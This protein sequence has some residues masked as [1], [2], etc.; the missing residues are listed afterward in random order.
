ME[1]LNSEL[2]LVIYIHLSIVGNLNT[3][4]TVTRF[5]IWNVS[6]ASNLKFKN[7]G[8]GCHQ[9]KTAL[10][11]TMKDSTFDH[12]TYTSKQQELDIFAHIHTFTAN[13]L[14][15]AMWI[16]NCP[17]IWRRIDQNTAWKEWCDGDG[18]L[19]SKWEQLWD[20]RPIIL[21]FCAV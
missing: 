15:S 10:T 14:P 7:S 16:P 8:W 9:K 12:K 18:N 21:V 19:L 3:S 5:N 1:I 4:N 6:N 20:C 11:D 2:H 17:I 13:S